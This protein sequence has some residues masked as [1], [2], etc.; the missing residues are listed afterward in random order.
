MEHY[1]KRKLAQQIVKIVVERELTYVDAEELL[2]C[3]KEELRNS[4]IQIK[5]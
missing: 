3:V 4:V 2:T 5:K 1:I